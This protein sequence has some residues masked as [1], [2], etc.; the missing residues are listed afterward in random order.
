LKEAPLSDSDLSDLARRGGAGDPAAAER[1]FL[2]LL[3]R[4]RNLVRYLIRGDR[5]V[6]DLSQ[7]ALLTLLRGLSSYRGEGQFRAW[8]DRIV[9][10]SVFASRRRGRTLEVASEAEPPATNEV[11][12]GSEPP[13]PDSYCSR[14]E[15][16][17]HLDAL[18]EAQRTA[19]VLHHVLGM[20]VPEIATELGVAFE[21]V[22]SRLKQGREQLRRRLEVP[23]A[24][25]PC[26]EEGIDVSRF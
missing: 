11:S 12:H 7:E 23:R 4:V 14:R 8:V 10:R 1:L 13:P 3:P 17:R 15:M 2:V 5:D 6:D 18:Q 9:A 25:A 22:R 16:A 26:A 20:T 21:T 24:G 19:L